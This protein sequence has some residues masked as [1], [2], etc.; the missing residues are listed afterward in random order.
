M[1]DVT[2]AWP[3]LVDNGVSSGAN[4]DEDISES[5]HIEY[6]KPRPLRPK[7]AAS[8]PMPA[9]DTVWEGNE[10]SNVGAGGDSGLDA[11]GKPW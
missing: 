4:E 11:N 6:V 9:W 8:E 2:E 5:R 10:E 3:D 7:P 1:T